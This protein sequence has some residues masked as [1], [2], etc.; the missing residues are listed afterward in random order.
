MK[1]SLPLESL[2]TFFPLGNLLSSFLSTR[3]S[4]IIRVTFVSGRI[5]LLVV[6]E[7][8]PR[9]PIPIPEAK[10]KRKQGPLRALLPVYV[11]IAPN[12]IDG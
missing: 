12:M 11:A 7:P 9:S 2:L 6:E 4:S 3:I 1:L 5:G 10:Q 8:D